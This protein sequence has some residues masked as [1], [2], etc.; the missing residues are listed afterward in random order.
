MGAMQDVHVPTRQ[1]I[2]AAFAEARLRDRREGLTVVRDRV[3]GLAAIRDRANALAAIRDRVENVAVVRGGEEG[4]SAFRHG[5]DE[6]P[7][8]LSGVDG[9]VALRN[10][11]GQRPNGLP[12]VTVGHRHQPRDRRD[13][14]YG[15]RPP[16]PY[17][18]DDNDDAGPHALGACKPRGRSLY[19][20][21]DD[22]FVDTVYPTATVKDGH[23]VSAEGGDGSGGHVGAGAAEGRDAYNSHDALGRDEGRTASLRK[24]SRASSDVETKSWKIIDLLRDDPAKWDTLAHATRIASDAVATNDD[25]RHSGAGHRS[26]AAS[27]RDYRSHVLSPRDYRAVEGVRPDGF[28]D[29]TSPRDYRAVEGVRPDGFPDVTS[30]RGFPDVTSPRGFPDVTSPRGF[31]DVT[32]PRGHRIVDGV[33]PDGFPDAP[34]DSSGDGWSDNRTPSPSTLASPIA[35]ELAITRGFTRW[36]S[37][38]DCIAN[39]TPTPPTSS[40]ITAITVATPEGAGTHFDAASTLPPNAAPPS[41]TIQC[42]V[43]C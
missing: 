32:S 14:V 36:D 7:D 23:S 4:H 31:P 16:V 43:I 1:G 13:Q 15:R 5:K 38:G 29:V 26:N 19:T 37:S 40:A 39:A 2:H 8:G 27:P 18:Q 6:R 35:T 3:D 9:L 25:W 12:N 22:V 24:A 30:P 41:K 11:E 20:Y 34:R 17:T 10:R 42:C 33:M 21:T 28:P